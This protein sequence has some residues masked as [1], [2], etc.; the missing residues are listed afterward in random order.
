MLLIRRAVY[1]AQGRDQMV[2]T[3]WVRVVMMNEELASA[4]V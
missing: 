3:T 4:I 2:L 1:R